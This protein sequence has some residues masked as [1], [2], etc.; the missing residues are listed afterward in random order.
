[1][2]KCIPAHVFIYLA[3]LC[4]LV[5]AFNPSF[6][7]WIYFLSVQFSRS[8]L[9]DSWRPHES[10]AR[11]LCPWDSPG[12]N[13]GVGWH[14][15]EK[16]ILP[17]NQTRVSCVAGRF[18]TIW[19]MR[20]AQSTVLQLY[21]AIISSNIFSGPSSL[22]LLGPLYC[23]CWCVL[24]LSQRSLRLSSLFS[25]LYSLFYGSD[26]HHSVLQVTYPFFCLSY[27]NTDSF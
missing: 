18:F 1:M 3:S 8:V 21:S 26:F 23:K 6:L 2:W 5:G 15:L 25:F 27:S 17:R 10:L 24:M 11:L 19:A 22:L 20:E 9:S 7:N 16:E 14:F 12:K 4:L 13:T